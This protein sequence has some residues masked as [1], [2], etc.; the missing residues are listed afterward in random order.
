V[1]I[2]SQPC[3][4]LPDDYS[5]GSLDPG[6]TRDE[7]ASLM[8]WAMDDGFPDEP[9]VLDEPFEPE[10]EDREWWAQASLAR[11]SLCRPVPPSAQTE[12]DVPW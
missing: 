8:A 10:P 7:W 2:V 4:F 11:P 3:S 12:E 1:P 6:P 9:P 5:D